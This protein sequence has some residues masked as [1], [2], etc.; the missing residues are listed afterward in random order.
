MKGCLR[1]GHGQGI[2]G[3][4]QGRAGAG[5]CAWC[6]CAASGSEQR[7]PQYW[8]DGLARL[9]LFVGVAVAT[10]S[11]AAG[12]SR[13]Q[14][15]GSQLQ[16]PWSVLSCG[17]AGGSSSQ[18]LSLLRGG[19]GLPPDRVG[20]DWLCGNG[21]L[22]LA[23]HTH[24]ASSRRRGRVSS[25]SASRARDRRRGGGDPSS[26]SM[27]RRGQG[28]GGRREQGG[29]ED[30]LFV[31]SNLA[32]TDRPTM[33]VLAAVL[34]LALAIGHA[35]GR[36]LTTLPQY[37]IDLNRLTV[38]G[39]SSGGCARDTHRQTHGHHTPCMLA[40][41]HSPWG[42]TTVNSRPGGLRRVGQPGRAR[43]VSN[44]Q[45]PAR[46]APPPALPCTPAFP[47]PHPAPTPPFL[48]P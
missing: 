8:Q 46:A 5:A 14:R 24:R 12:C 47:T 19:A 35:H 40:P 15:R 22:D 31:C 25:R 4:G 34:A 6:L 32:P 2:S 11:V 13:P 39:L 33:R 1:F 45:R 21:C 17:Y 36:N 26:P 41:G 38:G 10:T 23:R 42:R 18:A 27:A 29:E 3:R 20:G 48:L 30:G 37:N 28:E 9:V 7:P 43:R 16:R 44:Y